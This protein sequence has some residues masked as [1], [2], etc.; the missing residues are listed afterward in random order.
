MFYFTLRVSKK[1]NFNDFNTRL[2]EPLFVTQLTKRTL[3]HI[4][5]FKNEPLHDIYFGTNDSSK[6]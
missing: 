2:T 1:R 5:D 4:S 3:N 6:Q